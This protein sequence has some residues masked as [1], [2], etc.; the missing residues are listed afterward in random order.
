MRTVSPDSIPGAGP[1]DRAAKPSTAAWWV[2]VG[3]ATLL[4]PM[5][6][7][8][9]F[10]FGATWDERSRHKY[11]QMV[12]QFLRGVRPRSTFIEDGGNLYGGLFDTICAAAETYVDVDRYV[13]RHAIDA[14]F[15]WAG[16]VYAGRL[17]GRLFGPW[18]GVLGMVLLVTSPRYLADS[19]NNPKDLPFAA[20][21]VAVLY[22]YSTVSPKWPYLSLSTAAKISVAVA[23]ALNIRA[24]ALLYLGYLG[25]LV[26]AFVIIERNFSARRLADTLARLVGVTI[27]VLLLGTLFWPWAQAS[28]FIRPIEALLAFAST[29]FGGDVLYGGRGI[30]STD[31][32]WHYVPVWFAIS[33]PP[34]VLVGIVLS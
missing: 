9:S 32:P 6:V 31:L 7:M 26:A 34:I 22:Y 16:V 2:F 14:I 18:A 20:A 11:G 19:M 30:S 13:L 25:L 4:L 21:T 33:A 15:G 17:A 10:D 27:A 1:L 3:L 24:A 23:V 28:P 5:M 29:P 8:A 12:W